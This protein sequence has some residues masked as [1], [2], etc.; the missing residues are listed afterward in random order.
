MIHFLKGE[1]MA[2]NELSGTELNH[3]ITKALAWWFLECPLKSEGQTSSHYPFLLALKT[4]LPMRTIAATLYRKFLK[5][6]IQISHS[7]AGITLPRCQRS[8]FLAPIA[9]I[10]RCE[11]FAGVVAVTGEVEIRQKIVTSLMTWA[12][13]GVV[14]THVKIQ[15]FAQVF[16]GSLVPFRGAFLVKKNI[17]LIQ[18]ILLY[19]V[20]SA[21]A[22]EWVVVIVDLGH[23][24][25][26]LKTGL[27]PIVVDLRR[28]SYRAIIFTNR[29][30]FLCGCQLL[31][32]H[33]LIT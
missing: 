12:I 32:L 25:K 1:Q 33:S 8:H 23:I 30:F 21:F 11:I 14:L 4:A 16:Q 2:I 9:P 31:L 22:S 15:D 26:E 17:F 3:L 10:P 19:C 28:T 6:L 29:N 7:A 5:R 24:D 13:F 20:S 27:L 18:K